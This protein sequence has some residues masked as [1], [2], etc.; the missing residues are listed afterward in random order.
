MTR[1]SKVVYIGPV[2]VAFAVVMAPW[3]VWRMVRG[4]W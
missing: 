1:N 2:I 4:G 3:V